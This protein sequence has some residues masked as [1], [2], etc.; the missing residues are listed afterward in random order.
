MESKLARGISF[1]F[2]IRNAGAPE[3]LSV[4]AAD[5]PVERARRLRRSSGDAERKFW[6]RTRNRRLGGFKI[7]RQVPIGP[8]IVDFVCPAARLVIE[9]DGDQHAEA[10]AYD[11][12]RTRYLERRGYRVIR[13]ATHEVL[14]E[15]ELVLD[16]LHLALEQGLIELPKR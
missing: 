3:R 8:Y 4:R 11:A 7:R 2:R 1:E 12:A 13:F 14:H 15:I 6:S 16:R 5:T 9:I 10:L